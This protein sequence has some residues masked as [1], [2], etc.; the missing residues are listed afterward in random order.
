[1]RAKLLTGVTAVALLWALVQGP[2]VATAQEAKDAAKAS[3]KA[4]S[5]EVDRIQDSAQI[6]DEI[7]AAPDKGIPRDLLSKAHC[8][9][10][11]PSMK[12]GAFIFGAKY[13]KGVMTCRN[14]GRT[15][16]SGPSNIQIEGGSFGLQIGGTATD[17]VMLVMNQEGARKLMQREFTLGA[18]AK[19]A[20]GPVGR[21]A[22]AQTDIGLDA[23]ILSYSRSKGAFAGLALEGATLR[24]D[25]SDNEKLYGRKVTH[26]EILLGKVPPPAAAKV[27]E[28]TLNKYSPAEKS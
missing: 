19:V 22:E 20:A 10:I 13:G 6:L 3:Q 25:D 28:N 27:L 21:S 14:S 9:V 5:D 4:V 12:E 18:D 15:G 24:P 2:A 17:V 26:E 1:M 7:M 16:W 11:I 8:V 23:Q